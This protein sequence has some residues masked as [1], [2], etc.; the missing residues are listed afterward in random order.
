MATIVK[1]PAKLTFWERIYL[2]AIL[3]GLGMTMGH[4]LKTL[5]TRGA[6][7]I[8]YPEQHKKVPDNYRGLHVMPTWEDGHIKCVACEMCSTV[9]PANAI[10]VI[11]EPDENPDI[12]K[13]AKFYEIDELR[14]I[15]CGFCEEVCPRDA[16]H[17]TKTYEFVTD[18]RK[19]FLYR[20]D[21]LTK[22][23]ERVQEL[24]GKEN[25]DR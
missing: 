11:A 21:R 14:C 8:R 6:V 2:P 22:T 5:F 20:M 16:I 7:T 1:K 23:R 25:R 13:R 19:G 15:F 10:Q 12:E 4:M 24:N 17:L 18:N 3:K 9:C